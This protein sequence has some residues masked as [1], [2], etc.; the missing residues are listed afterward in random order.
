MLIFFKSS[1]IDPFDIE[2]ESKRLTELTEALRALE[3]DP[4]NCV[5]PLIAYEPFSPQWISFFKE[6]HEKLE[7]KHENHTGRFDRCKIC[8]MEFKRLLPAD[9]YQKMEERHRFEHLNNV[10]GCAGCYLYLSPQLNRLIKEMELETKHVTELDRLIQDAYRKLE[11]EHHE[12]HDMVGCRHC[13]SNI[14]EHNVLDGIRYGGHREINARPCME[15]E[16]VEIF[17]NSGTTIYVI[18]KNSS[19]MFYL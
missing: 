10:L 4:F 5:P 18:S 6:V 1:C 8:L 2:E 11:N 9:V 13:Y 15:D 7:K 12:G 3:I 17:L 14:N 16:N 19:L